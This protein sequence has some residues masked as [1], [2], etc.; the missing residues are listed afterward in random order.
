MQHCETGNGLQSAFLL[1]EG[2]GMERGYFN[3]HPYLNPV[4]GEEEERITPAF[5]GGT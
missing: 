5:A 1:P 2:E 4:E 3:R